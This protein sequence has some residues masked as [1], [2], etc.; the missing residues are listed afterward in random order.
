M[1]FWIDAQLS[2]ALVLWI[3]GTFAAEAFRP[4]ALTSTLIFIQFTSSTFSVNPL[5]KKKFNIFLAFYT[6]L[7]YN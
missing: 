6:I 2:P 7:C 5:S 4:L 3:S 1:K